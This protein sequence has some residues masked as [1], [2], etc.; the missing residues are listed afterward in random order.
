VH[1]LR[2]QDFDELT[3]ALPRWHLR[4]RQL[5][6]GTRRTAELLPCQSHELP[7][8][9]IEER[10]GSRALAGFEEINPPGYRTCGRHRFRPPEGAF[11]R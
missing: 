10:L 6:R 7:E 4:C 3:D 9:A 5:G 1:T 11:G 8:V 2:T